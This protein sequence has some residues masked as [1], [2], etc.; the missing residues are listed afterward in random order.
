MARTV[1]YWMSGN[2]ETISAKP[3]R[4]TLN[5]GAVP[6]KPRSCVNPF[7]RADDTAIRFIHVVCQMVSRAGDAGGS[8]G[9]TSM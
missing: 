2:T 5:E 9:L 4:V 3:K 7:S 6:D 8:L 1:E